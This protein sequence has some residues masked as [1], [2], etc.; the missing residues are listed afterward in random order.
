MQ[1]ESKVHVTGNVYRHDPYTHYIGNQ[2]QPIQAL[3]MLARV[4][5]SNV[6]RAFGCHRNTVIRLHK[7][8][9]QTGGVADSRKPGRPRVTNPRTDRFVLTS[10]SNCDKFCKAVRYHQTDSVA[11]PQASLA[12]IWARRPYS[13]QVLTACHQAARL[14]CAQWHFCWGRQQWARVLFSDESRF[15]LSH[16]EF[17]FLKEEGDVLLITVSFRGTDL[18]VGVLWYGLALWAEGK[19]ISLLCKATSMLKVTLTR[20]CSLKLILSYKGMGLQY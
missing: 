16:H 12:P 5:V 13:G 19:Q 15:N 18:E 10:F 3:T 2:I 11:L 14:Q 7:R 17:E 9:K 8:F 20:F 1:S 6:S 4:D